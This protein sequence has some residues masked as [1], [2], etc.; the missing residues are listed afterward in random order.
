MPQSRDQSMI[1]HHYSEYIVFFVCFLLI[2]AKTMPFSHF[3]G[4]MMAII[5]SI[6]VL[7]EMTSFVVY[8]NTYI[9]ALVQK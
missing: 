1:I 2:Y 6:G 8:F 9:E 4:L 3:D 5:K 7:I